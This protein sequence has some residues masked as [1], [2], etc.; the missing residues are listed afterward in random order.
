MV[1]AY[2]QK[3]LKKNIPQLSSGDTVKV[4][5][6]VVEGKKTRVQIFEGLIIKMQN[7]A[8]INGSFT[9]RKL[10]TG[11]GVERTFPLH[12]PVIVK[13]EKT[14][15]SKV[16]RSKLYF[17]RERSGKKWRM[18]G[19]KKDYVS[20]EET[21][22]KELEAMAE[23][24]EKETPEQTAPVEVENIQGGEVEEAEQIEGGASGE[25]GEADSSK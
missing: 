16:R 25:P 7:G 19:E 21:Q 11:I 10:S 20:W 24:A 3:F 1:E 17:M 15:S 12:S 2:S 8:G 4:H 18:K 6:K 14:K 13:I 9:V 22:E 23:N 5:L